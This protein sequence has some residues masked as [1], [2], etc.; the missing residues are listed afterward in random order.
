M[1]ASGGDVSS[2]GTWVKE[3]GRVTSSFSPNDMATTR[4][5]Y[6]DVRTGAFLN[7]RDSSRSHQVW[8]PVVRCG[9]DGFFPM[10]IRCGGDLH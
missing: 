9:W 7:G 1:H 8:L 2:D 5:E 10:G 3:F 4:S 6:D